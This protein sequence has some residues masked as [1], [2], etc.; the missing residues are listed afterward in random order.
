MDDCFGNRGAKARHALGQPL[1]HASAMERK[2]GNSRAFH[3]WEYISGKGRKTGEIEFLRPALRKRKS[4]D[5]A[6]HIQS[7]R[8]GIDEK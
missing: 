5:G 8:R 1:R 4:R 7:V 2:V 3:V 6:Q